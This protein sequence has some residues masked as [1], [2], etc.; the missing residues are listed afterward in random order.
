MYKLLLVDGNSIINRAFYGQGRQGQLTAPDGTPTGAVYTFF[1]ILLRFYE[2]FEPTHI[3]VAFDRKEPTFRHERYAEYK[4]K[5]E[6]MPEDL[7]LQMPI[8]KNCLDALNIFAIEQIGYEADDIIG[9]LANRCADQCHVYILSGDRDDFQLLNENVSQIYPQTGGRM[10]LYT[11]EVLQEQH[12]LRPDQ[13]VDFKAL[14]GDS[15]DNIPGVKGIGE[16]TASKL[17]AEY[18][19]LDAL[20]QHADEIKG[21]VGNKLRAGKDL[22]YLSQELAR[23]DT[24]M[25]LKFDFDEMKIKS[26]DQNKAYSVFSELGFKSLMKR[27]GIE[28]VEVQLD[29]L[30]LPNFKLIDESFEKSMQELENTE[31]YFSYFE[32]D[33]EYSL[34]LLRAENQ[35]FSVYMTTLED[36]EAV[37][38]VLKGLNARNNTILCYDWKTIAKAFSYYPNSHIIDLHIAAYLLSYDVNGKSLLDLYQLVLSEEAIVLEQ[39]KFKEKDALSK[40]QKQAIIDLFN[41]F[42]LYS[43]LEDELISKELKSLAEEIDY[44]LASV[45]ASMESRGILMDKDVLTTLGDTF[46][47]EAERLEKEIYSQAGLEF[48][49]NSPKQ[50]GTVLFENLGFAAGKKTASGN[51]STAASELERLAPMYPIVQDILDYRTVSKLDSTFIQ[52]LIKEI[53]QTGRIHTTFHQ[54]LTTTGRL[55][56]SDPNLQNIPMRENQGRQIRKAFVAS[57]GYVLLD[58][59]YSQVELRLL[60]ILANDE[61][62]IAAFEEGADI[63]KRTAASIFNKNEED[64]TAD[65][66]AAAKTVN[67]SIIYGI[68]DYGL[69]QD[70][71][72]SRKEAKQYIEGYYDLYNNVAPYMD[73]LIAFGKENAYVETYFGRRRYIPELTAKNFNV[74]KFGE[75]AAMNAP[76]QGTAADIMKIA[77]IKM[78]DAII[79]NEIDA[80]ILLQVHDEL[81]LE[82]KEEDLERAS[83]LL[84]ETME[85]AANLSIPLEVEVSHAKNWFDC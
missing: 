75:R 27:F 49:I 5:R 77:M 25:D 3:A 26:P 31:L 47:A 53:D 40:P 43:T 69:S 32:N 59:D 74:R 70:L 48:N 22:A 60:A 38:S 64:V 12:N 42:K 33:N 80:H 76:I 37:R 51:Y 83:S 19:N 41:M 36:L 67:F 18:D 30:T 65:E 82:V 52:G 72:I 46:Q 39:V 20:Y 63:H 15:S 8:L 4:A 16:K 61:T 1:S 54:T 11:P 17:L 78:Q 35:E 21:A 66:R 71:G 68:S 28:E 29:L 34:F 79:E 84:K 56:S 13:I 55:S 44:P 2:E 14:M 9:T 57:P 85:G 50:L 62:L 6:G 7:A 45:L 81:L 24:N 23:I 73:R 58:A 10:T